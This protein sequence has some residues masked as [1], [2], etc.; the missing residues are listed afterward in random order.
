[1]ERK[2]QAVEVELRDGRKVLLR[3]LLTREL[4]GALQKAG[5]I[6]A[7]DARTL[8][9]RAQ[10]IRAS[11]TKIDGREIKPGELDGDQLDNF[12]C[13]ADKTDLMAGFDQL[14]GATEDA[15]SLGKRIRVVSGD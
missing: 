6:K 5:N 15:E 1:M 7:H 3:E 10:C 11:V 14:Q 13:M 2:L 8:E 9:Q 12:F 4:R